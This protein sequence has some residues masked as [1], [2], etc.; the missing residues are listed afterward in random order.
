MKIYIIRH[1]QS[2][3]NRLKLHCGWSDTPL[4]ELGH[5]QARRANAY[6][7]DIPFDCVYCS[8]LPRA[9]QT[10][11]DALPGCQPI[12]SPKL[13]EIGVGTLADHPIAEVSAKYGAPYWE[14][15]RTQDFSAYGG[16]TQ[17]QMRERLR[18]F[19]RDTLEPLEGRCDTVAVF[20]HEGTVHQMLSYALGYDV[21]LGHLQVDNASVSVFSYKGGN[22]KLLKWNHTGAL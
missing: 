5:Q 11:Q 19:F 8:D 18:S 3:G 12:Y 14:H 15:V 16:E 22:W 7:K 10:A 13:R 21:L 17:E 6:L 20:G 1:G 9:K 2:E 4:S